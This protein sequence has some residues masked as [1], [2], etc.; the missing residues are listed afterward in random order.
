MTP[1]CL[2]L[3]G[4][5]ALGACGDPN[6][7]GRVEGEVA[8]EPCPLQVDGKG[9]PTQCATIEVPLW[10]DA[11]GGATIELFAQRH[12][13]A[14]GERV[15]WMLPGGPG[16]T[17]AVYETYVKS[18]A[19]ALPDTDLYVF[20]HRGVGRSTRLSCP[21][22]EDPDSEEGIDVSAAEWPGCLDAVVAEW[23]D[24]LAAFSSAAAA[25]DLAAWID[26][27]A[28]GREVFVY[29]ASY[30]TTLAHRFLQRH[31][32]RV[33]GVILDSLALDV[34]HRVY[35]A[36]FDA[37]ARQVLELCG[38]DDRCAEALGDDPE[39]RAEEVRDAVAD[40]GCAAIDS[41]TLRMG[42]AA[43]ASDSSL[44]GFAPAL[45][46]RAG[47]CTEDD[48]ADLE[49]LIALF[50]DRPPHYTETLY[51]PI[52]F[53]NI[54]LSEQWP[55]PWPDLASLEAVQRDAL[56]SFQVGTSQRPLLDTWPRY[57]FD[58]AVDGAL[59]D[60][61]VPLLMLHGDL[62]PLTPPRRAD[63]AEAHF[64]GPGQHMVRFPLGT[65]VLL[66]STP[67]RGGDCATR[68]ITAF[69]DDP[70]AAPDA[71]CVESQR[72]IDFDGQGLTSWLL[73]SDCSRYGNG[74]GGRGQEALLVLPLG[75]GVLRRRRVTPR[76]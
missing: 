67:G 28:D 20:E 57:A 46:H 7:D 36:E 58:P 39:A 31:D 44:R 22:Q 1:R 43:F 8:W 56:F 62:D 30:G 29:G 63:G 5:L 51:S 17:G 35:D 42:A 68:L 73:F 13:S 37:V 14:R 41:E 69:L 4:A 15:L 50:R 9:Q 74:C 2:A 55:E 64:V 66:G 26:A 21:V 75:L 25:D 24:D 49:R 3:V 34:D 18:L 60:T 72:A 45:F 76:A 52:L 12:L 6:R 11:P 61:A 48:I 23:G 38:D 10:W 54:E 40:G 47:R 33:D 53:A 70:L 65:H 16:Q 27:T 19:R 71:S 59:A 32:D